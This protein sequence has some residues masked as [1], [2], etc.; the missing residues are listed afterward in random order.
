[1]VTAEMKH[2]GNVYEA[3]RVLKKPVSEIL[4]F[5]ASINPLG[6]SPKALRA[7]QN[8][9]GLVAHYPDPDCIDL[10][11]TLADHLSQPAS[12]IVVANG[13]TELIH[14]IPRALKVRRVLIVG[15]TFSEYAKAVCLAGGQYSAIHA[16]RKDNYRPP[17]EYIVPAL[18]STRSARASVDA[19]FL[20]HPNSPTGQVC[21]PAE[22]SAVIRKIQREGVWTIL[23]E[24]FLEY[25]GVPSMGTL[26][27]RCPRLIILRSFT[28]FYALPG[29]RI[30]YAIASV[31]VA[32]VLREHLP[33]WSV[34]SVGQAAAKAAL[35]DVT[36]SRRSRSYTD[37][38]RVRFSLKLSQL[39]GLRVFPSRCN[40]V[41]VEFSSVEVKRAAVWRLRM[42]GILVR[43]CEGVPGLTSRTIRVAIK[44]SAENDRLVRALGR[45]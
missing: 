24:T 22:L 6:P 44:T 4:D 43:D 39:P 38:E 18:R 45:D 35:T 41:L 34:G 14:L 15:P 40:F 7:I 20:C 13:S 21:D 32:T 5:S 36:H 31:P 11:R 23:D 12:R 16:S 2:G 19:V 27:Q 17:I 37:R 10:R 9:A 25:S 42:Q 1:M 28:K 3:S 30:G 29:L 8:C 33:I 26:I